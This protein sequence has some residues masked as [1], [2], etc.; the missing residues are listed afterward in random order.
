[1]GT[2]G[3]SWSARSTLSNTITP[4]VGGISTLL[5]QTAR[6]ANP[7][8][9]PLTSATTPT[10]SPPPTPNASAPPTLTA[11]LKDQVVSRFSSLN[12]SA[13]AHQPNL[14]SA[15]QAKASNA[16]DTYLNAQE[17]DLVKK[18][19]PQL[20]QAL[21]AVK[22]SASVGEVRTEMTRTLKGLINDLVPSGEVRF[23]G[24]G[25]RDWDLENLLN[26][27]N[28][29]QRMPLA[30]RNQLKGITFERAEKAELPEGAPDNLLTRVA[31]EITAGHYNVQEKTVVLYDRATHDDFPALSQTLQNS[32]RH[33]GQHTQNQDIAALQNMLNPYLEGMGEPPLQTEGLWSKDTE[34]AVRLVQVNVLEKHLS[35]HYDLSPSQRQELRELKTLAASPHFDTIAR[36]TD[37][38]KKMENLNLLPD[39][40]MK[41]LLTDFASSNFGSASLQFIMQDLSENFGSTKSVSFAEGVLTHEMGHHIQLGQ[42]DSAYYVQEFSKLGQWFNVG[43]REVSSGY[44][45]G[46]FASEDVLDVYSVLASNGSVDK[47]SYRSAIDPE[48]RSHH[49][50]STY[51][52][53]DPME[54]FAESYKTFL[55]EPET[56]MEK[57]PEKFFFLNAMPAIQHNQTGSHSNETQYNA[58]EILGI[59]SKALTHK[60]GQEPTDLHVQQ[61]IRE[62]LEN[63]TISPKTPSELQLSPQVALSIFKSHE[64]LLSSVDM[65]NIQAAHTLKSETSGN[66]AVYATIT[67]NAQKF[68]QTQGKDPA[69][70]TFFTA[71][72]TPQGVERLFPKASPELKAQL[73]DPAFSSMM[74][75]VGEIAGHAV[76]LNQMRIDEHK[77]EKQYQEAQSYFGKI[78]KD[79]EQLLSRRLLSYSYDALRSVGSKIYNPET[80]RASASLHFF[81]QLKTN[82]GSALGTVWNDLPENFK[83]KLNDRSFIKS[84][85]GDEGRYLPSADAIQGTLTQIMSDLEFDRMMKAAMAEYE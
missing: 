29:V 58:Q 51:A 24:K 57:S 28:A 72:R 78:M 48:A 25:N 31:Q 83:N 74:L 19:Q 69:A 50:V 54:D 60:W 68:I 55:I 14:V 2:L 32:L 44:V 70:K 80:N 84:I 38:H 67:E 61:F 63:L 82:P 77:D 7:N 18:L 30:Q 23:K 3:N 34:R 1:M 27:A 85:S 47:G 22:P 36:M 33:I 17:I 6:I 35:S 8:L 12:P 40:Q 9:A 45:G 59:A 49:F 20:R 75:A 73:K 76:L 10:S 56:L 46:A 5:G 43:S 66:A 13:V 37:I 39:A 52:T 26:L 71:L 16:L 11:A 42:E 41:Q 15:P 79:P 65:P 53:T 4:K 64:S 21:L 62:K 81:E